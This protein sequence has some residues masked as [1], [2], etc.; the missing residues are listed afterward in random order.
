MSRNKYKAERPLST[1]QSF[2]GEMSGTK[3]MYAL[4]MA[5]A[6]VFRLSV[7][8]LPLR[9]SGKARRS[10]DPTFVA[11]RDGRPGCALVDWLSPEHRQMQTHF[12]PLG[13]T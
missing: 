11:P 8:G 1:S 5:G 3:G 13:Q 12:M 10:S 9:S 7:P 4:F 6:R 2:D